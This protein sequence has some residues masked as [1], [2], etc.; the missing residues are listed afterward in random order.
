MNIYSDYPAARTRQI[1]VDVFGVVTALLVVAIA[2]AVTATIRTLGA[3]GRDLEIAGRDFQ[4]GLSGAADNLGEVPLI[5]GGIRG[6]FDVAAAAGESIAEAGRAQ[7][8]FVEAIAVGAGWAVALI[9]LA[10]LALVWVLP[11]V[12]FARRSRRLRAFV[13][14]GMSADTLAARAL[15]RAPLAQLVAVHPDPAAAWRAQDPAVVRALAA[16][17]LRRAGIRADTLL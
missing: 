6:P 9:P 14:H 15:A 1:I 4:T 12:V 3:F 7:Q 17:E 2:T 10:L 11:R 8:V 5:G 16:I 13:A